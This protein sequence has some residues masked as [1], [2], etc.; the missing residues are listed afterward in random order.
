M[1][2]ADCCLLAAAWYLLLA[3]CC[4]LLP[5]TTRYT[6]QWTELLTFMILYIVY[7]MLT[8]VLLLNLLIA[9]MGTTFVVVQ[10]DAIRLLAA[11]PSPPS[12]PSLQFTPHL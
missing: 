8:L 1:P 11:S 3:A 7:T 6:L 2:F 12:H 4:L 10:E 9:M 5:L